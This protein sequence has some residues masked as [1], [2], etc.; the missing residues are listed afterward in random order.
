MSDRIP[1]CSSDNDTC[2]GDILDI[3]KRKN[4]VL[5][6]VEINDENIIQCCDMSNNIEILQLSIDAD[7]LQDINYNEL[8]NRSDNVEGFTNNNYNYNNN[9][10]KFL[11]NTYSIEGI[12]NKTNNIKRD[13][14]IIKSE[15]INELAINDDQIVIDC[16]FAKENDKYL[17]K[18]YFISNEENPLPEGLNDKLKEG[19]NIQRL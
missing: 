8:V 17:I 18:V 5:D 1:G 6:N 19:I 4:T 12:D 2:K 11:T 16:K 3:E 9:T 13:C 7:N 10:M 14:R 15:L